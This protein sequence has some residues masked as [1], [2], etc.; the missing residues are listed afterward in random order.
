VTINAGV[1]YGQDPTLNMIHY[2]HYGISLTKARIVYHS[3]YSG[4]YAYLE[5][6]NSTATALV[7]NV[8]ML[9]SLGWSLVTPSTAGSIPTG[10][11]NQEITFYDGIVTEGQ[12]VSSIG[13]GIAPLVVSSTTT[14]GNL[15]ADLLDG[16]HAATTATA[17]TIVQ[18]DGNGYIYGV[19]INSSRANET[20]AAASYIY[21]SGD[22]WLR[23]KTLAN[24]QAELVTKTQV[25]TV[26][27]G[28]ITSHTHNYLPLG[29]GSLTGAI[30]TNSNTIP[31][32]ISRSS[33]TTSECI[34]VG[35]DD[36]QTLFDYINDEAQSSINFKVTNT[37][38]ETG[39]GV[40]A[41]S[42]IFSI[43]SSNTG[44]YATLGG[45]TM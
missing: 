33:S 28:N 26:L 40:N 20:S 27:T 43:T 16:C 2:T 34:K 13:T 4:N 9:S 14:V 21:D 37:D 17:N 11:S 19:Y 7:V 1:M 29:G 22:G 3:T 30:N 39:G 5:V 15:N 31:L 25:E 42:V 41:N 12:L 32:I 6:Y 23:K 35:V 24:A 18:R 45:K 38:T 8:Q 36:G 44:Y 10:Y